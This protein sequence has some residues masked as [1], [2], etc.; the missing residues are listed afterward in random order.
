MGVYISS[1]SQVP[2]YLSE[3]QHSRVSKLALTYIMEIP[4]LP[5]S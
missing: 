4:K 1:H 2:K 5:S 3:K